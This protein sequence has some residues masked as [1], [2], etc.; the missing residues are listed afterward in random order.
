MAGTGGSL[1]SQAN[2]VVI[3]RR[4]KLMWALWKHPFPGCLFHGIQ[5]ASVLYIVSPIDLKFGPIDDIFVA[6]FLLYML[7]EFL[8]KAFIDPIK[9]YLGI[10]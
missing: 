2:P 10:D 6:V 4:I 7:P 9:E 8:P 3:A 1:L 5:L